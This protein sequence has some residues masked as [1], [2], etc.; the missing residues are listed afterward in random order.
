MFSSSCGP[1]SQEH[2]NLRLKFP[3]SSLKQKKIKVGEGALQCIKINATLTFGTS[4]RVN[5]AAKDAINCAKKHRHSTSNLR[6][7]ALELTELQLS[8]S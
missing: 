7:W 3:I 6:I 1:D 8:F 4:S 5:Y 2:D